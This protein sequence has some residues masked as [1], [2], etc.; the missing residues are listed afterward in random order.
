MAQLNIFNSD[1]SALTTLADG[2]LI[3]VGDVSASAPKKITFGNLKA[4]TGGAYDAL[5]IRC[6]NGSVS[7]ISAGDLV[8]VAGS[9][10]AN[11]YVDITG[12]EGNAAYYLGLP[13]GIA[14]TNIAIDATGYMRT[15]GEVTKTLSSLPVL[16]LGDPVYIQASGTGSNERFDWTN[17]K[18]TS[19]LWMWIGEV[20]EVI[21]TTNK[22]YKLW[23]D[24]SN[25]HGGENA[26]GGGGVVSDSTLTGT[27]TTADVL[28]V[29]K[30]WGTWT[31]LHHSV[32][33]GRT[34]QTGAEVFTLSRAVDPTV[35][36]L[37]QVQFAIT[38]SST[39]GDL[40]DPT[41]FDGQPRN[42][43]QVE[44]ALYDALYSTSAANFGGAW[45]FLIKAVEDDQTT[46]QDIAMG[47][48]TSDK[49]MFGIKRATG[50][51]TLYCPWISFNVI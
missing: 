16:S 19:G 14:T 27:G 40:T 43:F 25:R 12:A 4:Q 29:A 6:K 1:I 35:D 42:I 22:Q 37:V 18:P 2:D 30:P 39:E 47:R 21:S 10:D 44:A 24:F 48:V 36:T 41:T 26:G 7:A 9:V 45:P 32:G 51:D 8:M 33:A 49:T 50:S 23:V 20:F 3:A 38:Q 28:K 5:D 13:T 11:G 15:M 34:I 31:N 17:T 46:F